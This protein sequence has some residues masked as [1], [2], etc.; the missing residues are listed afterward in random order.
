MLTRQLDY[1]DLLKFCCFLIFAGNGIA[2]LTGTSAMA[3]I[4]ENSEEI[5][6]IFGFLLIAFSAT[7]LPSVSSIREV[8]FQYFLLLPTAILF[9]T[10]YASFVKSGYV[11]EQIIEHGIKLLAPIVLFW[12]LTSKRINLDNLM[13]VLKVLIAITFIG[14]GMFALGLH[15]V[16][17]GFIE[18]TTEL[19]GIPISS[20]YIFL[21]VIGVLDIVCAILIFFNFNVKFAYVYLVFW[22]LTTAAARLVYGVLINEGSLTEL[23][24]WTSNMLYRL[25]YGFIAILVF[26]YSIKKQRL[27]VI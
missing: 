10:T 5:E 26:Q 6:V 1:I 25:P 15:Y 11:P 21:Q 9:V 20:A 8:N 12:C 14:H 23:V 24:Y 22:G 19:L 16:P 4:F 18:M 13:L 7:L 2:L 3:Y 27:S 17:G